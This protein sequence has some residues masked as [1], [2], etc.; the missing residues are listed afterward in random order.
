MTLNVAFFGAGRRAQP[1]LQA[2]AQHP[3]VHLSAVCD[4]DLR[5]AEQTAAGWGARVFPSPEALL[6]EAR[7]D[8]LWV[9][10]APRL[11]ADILQRAT[12]LR[13][14]CFIEPPGAADFA[15]ARD[16]ARLIADACLITMVGFT[17]R[18]VDVVQEA[19]GYL[20][21]NP[22][23]LVLGWWLGLA[24]DTSINGAGELLWEHA[25]RFIDTFRLF[26]GEA[27]CVRALVPSSG[28]KDGALVLQ[29]EFVSGTIGVLTCAT[30]ARPEPRIEM[31]LMG[32]GW[33]LSFGE[34]LSTLR[35]A[36]RDKTTILRSLNQAAAD[37][38]TAFLAAVGAG[39]PAAIGP[40]YADALQTLAVCEAAAVSIREGRPVEIDEVYP[41]HSK[42][43]P[44]KPG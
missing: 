44:S 31:E 32:E 19:R 22:I 25:C 18:H 23:P 39:S 3:D 37:Q 29:I 24:E 12:E 7:P 34:G 15:K 33:T 4:P 2:L 5:A 9:C 10:V 14:P 8:A 13:I 40:D 11:Q 20:G 43:R 16:C 27:N 26:C 1:Y 30:F 28:P 42:S 21:A 17:G 6:Q 38:V 35:L 41:T 36:E